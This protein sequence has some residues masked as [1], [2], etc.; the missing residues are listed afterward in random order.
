MQIFQ[1]MNVDH[2]GACLNVLGRRVRVL[3]FMKK[4][5][6]KYKRLE[7]HTGAFFPPILHFVGIGN[8]DLVYFNRL[9]HAVK[10]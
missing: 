10:E 9:N 5:K 6:Y 8:R 4:Y 1:N 3:T 2:V 7:S